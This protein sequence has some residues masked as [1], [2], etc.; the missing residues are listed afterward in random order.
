MKKIVLGKALCALAVGF[1]CLNLRAQN[2]QE[3]L[4][5]YWNYREKYKKNFVR[6]GPSQGEGVNIANIDTAS[7]HI[8]GET[9]FNWMNMHP[10]HGYKRWGD[11]MAMQGDYISVLAT[12]YKLLKN[13]GKPTT[14]VLNELYYAIFAVE[15]LDKNAEI[16]YDNSQ[17][18]FNIN[19]NGFF[20]RDDADSTTTD[21]WEAEYQNTLDYRDRCDGV[22]SDFYIDHTGGA[23]NMQNEMSQDQMFGLWQGFLHVIK[24]VDNIYVKPTP[25]DAGFYLH[26]KVK[27]LT[28]R[29]FSYITSTYHFE[30]ETRHLFKFERNLLKCFKSTFCWC[31]LSYP[32]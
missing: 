15:R 7:S 31:S 4:K 28:N 21:D 29:M 3:N 13:A 30:N 1:F 16:Y 14:S 5:K 27:D 32:S 23:A 24:L 26:D 9:G 11:A 18:N 22:K 2:D 19:F 10:Q 17:T 25:N 12:E 8:S 6:I 20:I